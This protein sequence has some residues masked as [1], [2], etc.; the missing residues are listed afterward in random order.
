LAEHDPIKDLQHVQGWGEQQEVGEEAKDANPDKLLFE[1]QYAASN[2]AVGQIQPC[3]H[4]GFPSVLGLWGTT[5]M[6]AT[7]M[8]LMGCR[9]A[10]GELEGALDVEA[11]WALAD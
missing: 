6:A 3:T 8:V 1:G 7:V 2:L 9:F 4:D 10:L 11:C 5:G